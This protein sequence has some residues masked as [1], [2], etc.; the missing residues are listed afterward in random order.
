MVE[1]RVRGVDDRVPAFAKA[2]TEVY[3]VERHLEVLF[4]K[5]VYLLEDGLTQHHAGCGHG[6]VVRDPRHRAQVPL[7]CR[8]VELVGVRGD[9]GG[10]YPA[11]ADQNPGVLDAAVGVDELRPHRPH[12]RPLGVLEHRFQPSAG[13]HRSVVVEQDYVIPCSLG[14]G[15][16]VDP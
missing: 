13:D 14:D 1:L 11:D 2:Q 4:V 6:A 15:E 10:P 3:V 12:L 5:A 16:V 9:A 7:G 8:G